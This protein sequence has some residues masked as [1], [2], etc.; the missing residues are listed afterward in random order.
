M[1]NFS[2]KLLMSHRGL[3]ARPTFVVL[4]LLVA[5]AAVAQGNPASRFRNMGGGARGKDT[6]LQHRVEDT[7]SIN[8]RYLDSSRLQKLDSSITNF[9]RR[10]PLSATAVDLGTLGSASHDLVFKPFIQPGWDHGWHVFDP[11]VFTAEE[12][13]FYVTTKPWSEIG[14][15]IGSGSEQIINL[16]HTQNLTKY[17]N[18]SFQ[19]KLISSPGIY[20]SSNTNHNSYRLTSWYQSRSKRYQNFIIFLGSKLQSAENGGIRDLGYLDSVG[21]SNKYVIPTR[22]GKQTTYSASPF[23]IKITTGSFYT[24]GVFMMRQ[25]Y[26]LLGKK[27]SIVTD[28][29][30]TPLFYPRIRV[31]HTISYR[32]YHHIFRDDDADSTYYASHLGFYTPDSLKLSD[33]WH[34]LTNDLSFYSFPDVKNPQQFLKLGAMFQNL[35]GYYATGDRVLYNVQLH[36]EYR[37]KTRNKKWDVEANGGFYVSGYNAGD[38]N[39]YV[40]LQRQISRNIGTF[41]AGFEN[42]NRTQSTSFNQESSFGFGDTTGFFKQENVTHLFANLDLPR[43]KLRLGGNYY[44]LTNY[45]YFNNYYFAQQQ[46]SPFNILQISADKVFAISRHWIWR[47]KL[48]LQKVAGNSP[49]N[50]PLFITHNQFGYEG[51]LGF[52]NLDVAFGLE[53]RYYTAYKADGYSPVIGQFYTQNDSTIKQKAPDI[54]AYLNFRIRSFS[55]Y[56]R[57]ENLNT[58]AFNGNN[59][60]GFYNVNLVAPSYPYI[61]LRLRFGIF[62]AFVN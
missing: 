19:Y 52:R 53:G 21:Y 8:F 12:S 14:Y 18:M 6:S 60:F 32:T 16:T 29:T 25:Q 45:A 51:N 9:Y 30:V 4:L 47:T 37:N 22:L 1:A 26:D 24:T 43:L 7:I 34:N 15:T 36:G 27:D 33:T 61:G 56:V 55:M 28:S 23:G 38:Y 5:A 10:Y 2:A 41:Q 31:E 57:V 58:V 11:F 54:S 17:W 40:S 48:I 39:V 62:W 46:T 20:N 49:V 3:S 50:I 35:H 44:L 59:G 13:R 42:I